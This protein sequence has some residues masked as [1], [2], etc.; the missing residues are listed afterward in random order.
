MGNDTRE[1]VCGCSDMEECC[2]NAYKEGLDDGY[3]EGFEEGFKAS[4]SQTCKYE[5]HQYIFGEVWRECSVCH[6]R[7]AEG[8]PLLIQ[9]DFCPR[10]GRFIKEKVR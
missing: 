6:F 3:D 9:L 5:K 8:D 4:T 2:A 7:V 10:C 1:Y